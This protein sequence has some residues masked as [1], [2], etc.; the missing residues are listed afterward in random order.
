VPTDVTFES[1]QLRRAANECRRR[2][3]P[4]IHSEPDRTLLT[5]VASLRA[6]CLDGKMRD[7]LGGSLMNFLIAVL[8]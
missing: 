6:S 1:E 8:E 4:T 2:S 5:T 7:E 3:R